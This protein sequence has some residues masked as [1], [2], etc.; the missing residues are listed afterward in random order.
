MA[1]HYITLWSQPQLEVERRAA[2]GG[3]TLSHT[4]NAQFAA[5]GV[6]PGDRVYVVATERGRLLLLGRL[7]VERVVDQAEAERLLGPDVYEAPDH[8]IGRGTELRLDRLVPEDIAR[9]IER[10]SGK[11]LAI[12]ADRYRVDANSLRTTGA[13]HR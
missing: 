6:R 1:R 12:D 3:A 13:H 4:A 7:D 11:R 5:R 9:Q 8:L 2:T 10:E